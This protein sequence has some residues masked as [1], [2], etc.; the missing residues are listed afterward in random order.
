MFK[1]K[2]ERIIHEG[3]PIVGLAD[4]YEQVEKENQGVWCC[5]AFEETVS[6]S[7]R[8]K[9]IKKNR[10][11]GV[12]ID[13]TVQEKFI[14]YPT[15]A[16]LYNRTRSSTNSMWSVSARARHIRDTNL[17]SRSKWQVQAKEAGLWEP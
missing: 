14:R 16:K 9:V 3:H 4:Q 12:N 6:A 8:L 1:I 5:G 10:L 7:L 17:A 2:L 13:T 11:K 15:D